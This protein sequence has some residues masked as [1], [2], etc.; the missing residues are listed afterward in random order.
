MSAYQPKRGEIAGF[1][2]IGYRLPG[3]KIRLESGDIMDEFPDEVEVCGATYTLEFV[4]S[5]DP[6]G[7]LPDDHPGKYIVWG[8]YV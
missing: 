7:K 3:E 2:L 5:N 8:V 6:D 1:E 4:K